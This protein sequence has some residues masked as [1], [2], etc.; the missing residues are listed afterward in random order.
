MARMRYKKR[1]D[2]RYEAKVYLGMVD[3]K[4]K[5]KAVYGATQKEVQAKADA[6]RLQLGKGLDVTASNDSFAVW[7]EHLIDAKQ[8]TCSPAQAR[9][10]KTRVGYFTAPLG[11]VPI[12]R[13]KLHQLQGIIDALAQRNPCTGKP[14]AKKTLREYIIAVSQVFEYAINNRVIEHNPTRGIRIAQ[15]APKETRRALTLKERQMV[16]DTPHRAQ[17]AALLMML[18]GL[19]RGE[20]TALLWS[21]IDL[22]K[23]TISV[24]KSYDFKN[25]QMKA[26]KTASGR[27]VVYMPDDLVKH[28]QALPGRE[29]IVCASM[30]GTMMSETAWARL[31]QCYLNELNRCYGNFAGLDFAKNRKWPVM[32]ELFTPHCLRH[33]YC[34]ILYEAGIDVVTAKELMGHSDIKTTLGIYTHL[35]Q[36]KTEK[37]IQ[38]LNDFLCSSNARQESKESVDT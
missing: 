10:L 4:K 9:M 35:S 28:L 5:Y 20:V 7:A 11:T 33:T 16:L 30:V 17:T 2:G 21:D 18:A 22:D 29:G 38:R 34:T 27:R 19:R 6:V 36:E 8:R 14:T 26:P 12:G 3:G 31:W 24:T 13:I 15:D 37:D 32:I 25:R 23:K 1:P